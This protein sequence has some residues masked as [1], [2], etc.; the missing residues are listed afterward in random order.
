MLVKCRQPAR[1]GL[2]LQDSGFQFVRQLSPM[3]GTVAGD[4][5]CSVYEQEQIKS[6]AF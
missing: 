1:V 2:A 5:V 6:L 4:I 3:I